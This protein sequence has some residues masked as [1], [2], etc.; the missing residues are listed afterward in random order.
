MYEVEAKMRMLATQNNNQAASIRGN[1]QGDKGRTNDIV[2]T[3][4][5][6]LRQDGGKRKQNTRTRSA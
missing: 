2:G 1:E 5:G 4:V 3:M 6:D